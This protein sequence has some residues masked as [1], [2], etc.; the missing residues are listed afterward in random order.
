M[1]QV[2]FFLWMV[3]A[4]QSCSFNNNACQRQEFSSSAP[5]LKLTTRI[6]SPFP[7]ARPE[8]FGEGVKMGVFITSD[9]PEICRPKEIRWRNIGARAV[10]SHNSTQ[11]WICTPDVTLT[12]EAILP[13]AYYPYQATA[14]VDPTAVPIRL[15]TEASRTPSYH[16][17]KLAKGHKRVDC[18][19][20]M[21]ILTMEPVLS[22]VAVEVYADTDLKE[23]FYLQKIQIGNKPGY[24]AFCQK[25]TL[26]LL[27][28][29]VVA[30]PSAAGST[31]LH[32]PL[33]VRLDPSSCGRYELKVLPL[34]SPLKQ[35]EIEI[36]LTLN[37][38][39]YR[40]PLPAQTVWKKGYKHIYRFIFT[41][42]EIHLKEQIHQL[43]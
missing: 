34:D 20:P 8:T 11:E 42:E 23:T 29:Q 3:T 37:D 14:C 10:R 43:L 24:T 31:V 22:V 41:G 25:G 19:S 15:S 35:E 39:T 12:S 1:R 38:R 7:S 28:G 32:L 16:Y 36:V 2:L 9:Y 17:G 33:P 4:L 21:A 13:Y 40:Y 18:R 6:F 5:I 26:N 27:T 30:I